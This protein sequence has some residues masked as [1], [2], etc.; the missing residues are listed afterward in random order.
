MAEVIKASPERLQELL[1]T[2]A[3]CG[4]TLPGSASI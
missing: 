1:A 3:G 2:L 4:K